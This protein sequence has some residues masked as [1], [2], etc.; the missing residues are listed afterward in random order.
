MLTVCVE[1]IG[2]STTLNP[3]NSSV[4]M[5]SAN[6]SVT[7][8]L[9][10]Q[11]TTVVALPTASPNTTSYDW[12]R[13]NNASDSNSNNSLQKLCRV[14]FADPTRGF[15]GASFFGGM[16]VSMVGILIGYF[17]ISAYRQNVV[18]KREYNHMP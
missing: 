15:D 9:P 12:N 4:A 11:S 2:N 5:D 3:G 1:N 18:Q 13:G 6:I 16:L 17:V 7:T 8:S 14:T 10:S